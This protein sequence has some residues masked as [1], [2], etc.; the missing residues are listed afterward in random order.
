MASQDID[1]AIS[2]GQAVWGVLVTAASFG[3]LVTW[4]KININSLK[5]ENEERKCEIKDI[6]K[7]LKGLARSD[8]LRELKEDFLREMYALHG[9]E[10]P[11]Q[12][13]ERRKPQR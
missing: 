4:A 6:E 2:I 1:T 12:G 10:R 11:Y 5:K 9:I 7:E 8:E 13:S 3:G